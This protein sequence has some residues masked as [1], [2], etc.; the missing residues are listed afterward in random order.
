MRWCTFLE[1]NADDARNLASD[2]N[3]QPLCVGGPSR[4]RVWVTRD[5][6]FW[7]FILD[8]DLSDGTG[9]APSGSS[10]VPIL[11]GSA[12]AG[13]L[14]QKDGTAIR[15]DSGGLVSWI[16]DRNG[17]KVV[18]TYGT[19]AVDPTSYGRLT[20]AADTL[21]RSVTIDY[22]IVDN[23]DPTIFD[24]YDKITYHGTGGTSRFI[25]VHYCH[26]DPTGGVDDT[27]PNRNSCPHYPGTTAV[28]PFMLFG[29]QNSSSGKNNPIMISFVELPDS[30]RYEFSYNTYGEL[31][32][33]KLPTGGSF[34]YV[35]GAG[36]TS[37]NAD[38]N[39][40]IGLANQGAHL[41]IYRRV[42]ERSVYVSDGVMEGKTVYT[43]W[44]N[45][46]ASGVGFCTNV[47]VEHRDSAG[48]LL[49]AERHSFYGGAND[50][51]TYFNDGQYYPLPTEGKEY[52]TEFL[53]VEG[54]GFDVKTTVAL[55]RETQVWEQRVCRHGRDLSTNR[56]N[57]YEPSGLQSEREGR[58]A[59]GYRGCFVG[60]LPVRS[61]QQCDP[62]G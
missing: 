32:K 21:G 50:P 53:N 37:A 10:P 43:P 40:V 5:G 51:T 20:M 6:T 45:G 31:T 48:T 1:G 46:C 62:E 18:Y 16:R 19:N 34:Q 44:S 17:N 61:L 7:T 13:Y 22:S 41:Q 33:V 38:P 26:L 55:R 60:N 35:W 12:L 57:L 28:S 58:A 30:R 8:G 54:T 42:K 4:G 59:G 27:H 56:H 23:S 11:P 9:G 47:G 24:K 49:A 52:Q 39:G 29:Y 14:F 3:N 2:G 15:I 25:K 36:D